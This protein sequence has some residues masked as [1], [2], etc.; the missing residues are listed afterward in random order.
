MGL[1]TVELVMTLEE[2][3]GVRIS[4]SVAEKMTRPRDIT[5]WLIEQQ[6]AAKLFD[7]EAPSKPL[8]PLFWRST[9]QLERR[10]YSRAEIAEHVRRITIEQLGLRPE[11]YREE[12]RFIQ[13][14]HAD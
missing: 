1:D 5:D 9:S 8:F 11:E 10:L 2:T 6:S 13:D 7:D 3:F 4:D 14:F 12:G